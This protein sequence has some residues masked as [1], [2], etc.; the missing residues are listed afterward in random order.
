[1]RLIDAD[2]L[3]PDTEWDAHYDGFLS[4]S[5]S[6]IDAAPTIEAEPVKH[7]RWIPIDTHTARCPLCGWWQRTG[8]Y[9]PDDIE[10]FLKCYRFCTSCGTKMD[11]G[12]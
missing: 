3:E 4:Y 10:A 5:Q 9:L 11:G 2:A 1:M 7:G 8:I 12:D 6:Q